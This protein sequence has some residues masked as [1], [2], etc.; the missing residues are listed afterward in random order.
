V[1][2]HVHIGSNGE[3]LY[4]ICGVE[5]LKPVGHR[6]FVKGDRPAT[7]L[8][9]YENDSRQL[10]MFERQ[11]PNSK[12]ANPQLEESREMKHSMYGP[13]FAASDDGQSYAGGY[14]VRSGSTWA[15]RSNRPQARSPRQA[16][17]YVSSDRGSRRGAVPL[18]ARG[19]DVRSVRSSYY[20][21]SEGR[22][23]KSVERISTGQRR[24]DAGSAKTPM[25]GMFSDP[26]RTV[27]VDALTQA[28]KKMESKSPRKRK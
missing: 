17:S 10:P 5:D 23:S 3:V 15:E 21:E 11:R 7:A 9:Q 22:R 4:N 6:Q 18:S 25:S 28:L 26:S 2:G 20:S 24:S 12:R 13:A 16:E 8:C 19:S 14:S 27:T 1:S